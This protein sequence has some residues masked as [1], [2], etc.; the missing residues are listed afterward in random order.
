MD[1]EKSEM[2]EQTFYKPK[3]E[4]INVALNRKMETGIVDGAASLFDRSVGSYQT[5]RRHITQGNSLRSW[6][7]PKYFHFSIMPAIIVNCHT[8]RFEVED[9]AFTFKTL[10]KWALHP[11]E[12]LMPTYQTTLCLFI[13]LGMTHLTTV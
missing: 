5:T 2:D 3:A 6:C 1:V 10:R 11:T 9:I 7:F 4:I 12:K 8:E 13:Y